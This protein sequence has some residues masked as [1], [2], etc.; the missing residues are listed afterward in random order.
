VSSHING[1]CSV[2]L[3][4]NVP[5][6]VTTR[7][8][9]LSTEDPISQPLYYHSYLVRLWCE[10]TPPQWRASLRSIQTGEERRFAHVEQLFIFLYAQTTAHSDEEI[11]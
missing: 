11:L 2:T 10:P 6:S 9:N 8:V 4:S 3:S 7:E 5:S 1:V